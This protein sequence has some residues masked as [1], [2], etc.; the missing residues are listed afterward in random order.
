MFILLN[1][2]TS[3]QASLRLLLAPLPT[4]LAAT[5][6]STCILHGPTSSTLYPSMQGLGE[7]TL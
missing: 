6:L 1:S 7:P 5:L 2:V 3:L 4:L